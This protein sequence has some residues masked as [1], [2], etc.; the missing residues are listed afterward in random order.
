V[1]PG[2]PSAVGGEMSAEPLIWAWAQQRVWSQTA[3]RLKRRIDRARSVALGLA[4]AAATLAAGAV[5]LAD[6]ASWVGPTL[7]A[8]A[9]ISAGL[10]PIG[11]RRAGTDQ[12]R[13]WIR[14]RSASE[15]LKT[16]VYACLAGGSRYI[17]D[18]PERRLGERTADI[19]ASV[20]D[21]QRHSLGITPDTKPL[22]AV[23]GIDSYITERVNAQIDGYYRPK[24]ASFEHRV[25]RL[26]AVGDGLA[27]IAVVF[28]AVAASFHVPA[29]AA[30][31]PVVTTVGTSMV[32]Y[33]AAA[34]Y[35]YLIVE[36]LRTA[37]R[38]EQLRGSYPRD[39]SASASFV[40]DCEDAISI[41]NQGW[42]A[43][44]VTDESS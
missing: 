2:R 39:P 10:G 36:F 26:R 33:L 15:G 21:L 29:L 20:A 18:E 25:R 43:R 30:W 32:A 16:E 44:W 8:A 19:V 22:P 24:A 7:A 14:A 9:A 28:A 12:I 1:D 6:L 5:Q 23:V 3:N 4:I 40:D 41:E 38:L 31:V 11:Q 27:V 34:R 42:M 17:G 35:D 37:Q 13:S